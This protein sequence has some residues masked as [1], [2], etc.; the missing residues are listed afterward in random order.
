MSSCVAFVSLRCVILP[1]PWA[2]CG[3]Q[4]PRAKGAAGHG[5]V[6]VPALL[7]SAETLLAMGA[8]KPRHGTPWG[9]AGMEGG[10]GLE[11]RGDT[12]CMWDPFPL[13]PTLH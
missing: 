12:A 3:A 9:V 10:E 7:P 4:H 1:A 2:S 13:C 6:F 11:E 8:G 5:G